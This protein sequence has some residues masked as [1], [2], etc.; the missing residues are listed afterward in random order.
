MPSQASTEHP[1][2]V[3]AIERAAIFERCSVISAYVAHVQRVCRPQEDLYEAGE[4]LHVLEADGSVGTIVLD[5]ELAT[6]WNLEAI[7]EY[8]ARCD[9][10]EPVALPQVAA[11]FTA[12]PPGRSYGWMRRKLPS[13]IALVFETIGWSE[14]VAMPIFAEPIIDPGYRSSYAPIRRA[15]ASI[16]SG[17]D[18]SPLAG[19]TG[20][21]EAMA[22]L[23]EPL[24]WSDRANAGPGVVLSAPGARSILMTCKYLSLHV[25]TY[26]REE[27]ARLHHAMRSAGFDIGLPETCRE[28]FASQGG[29]RG[30]RPR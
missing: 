5:A 7:G 17:T 4:T 10:I 11:S 14:L 15:L 6:A 21:I 2:P 23:V 20:D 27:G 30:R 18:G 19:L 16:V 13:A 22:R 9:P 26:D 3:Q 29:I 12:V 1:H 25:H 24:L 28:R 8:E